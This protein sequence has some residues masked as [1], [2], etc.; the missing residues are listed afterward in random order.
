MLLQT[1]TNDPKTEISFMYPRSRNPFAKLKRKL[2][3]VLEYFRGWPPLFTG[4]GKYMGKDRNSY[5][6]IY[7]C[8]CL[9]KFFLGQIVNILG[10]VE[11][12]MVSIAVNYV[13]T[14]L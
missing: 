2:K 11:N 6:R 12:E 1:K 10:F 5:L 14:L 7:H 3:A 9:H 13:I 4:E 8:F